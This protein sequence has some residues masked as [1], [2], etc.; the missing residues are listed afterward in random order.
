MGALAQVVVAQA[1]DVPARRERDVRSCAMVV[2]GGFQRVG[3]RTQIRQEAR[4]RQRG[5]LR[6]YG[7]LRLINH[8]LAHLTPRVDKPQASLATFVHFGSEV[9]PQ[10][11][12]GASS[13]DQVTVQVQSRRELRAVLVRDHHTTPAS[14]KGFSTPPRRRN[15]SIPSSKSG[16]VSN[17][18][19]N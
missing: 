6:S 8:T 13:F 16:S 10:A 1:H 9:K 14:L 5:S 11:A 15:C 19:R 7:I 12:S 18:R 3:T 2:V 4:L 17:I